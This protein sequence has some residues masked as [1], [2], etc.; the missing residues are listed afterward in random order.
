MKMPVAVA[1]AEEVSLTIGSIVLPEPKAREL[2]ASSASIR[3]SLSPVTL[4][5]P[6]C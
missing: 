6:R 1:L 5:E 3:T 2:A 4:T